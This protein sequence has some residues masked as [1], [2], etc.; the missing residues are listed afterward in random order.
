MTSA[1]KRAAERVLAAPA[2]MVERVCERAYRAYLLRQAAGW[3]SPEQVRLEPDCLKLHT[4]SHRR[5]V[6]TRFEQAV[7]ALD[8]P[9]AVRS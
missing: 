4:G 8:P 5:S 7:R 3:R 1:W 2:A 9:D 6:L